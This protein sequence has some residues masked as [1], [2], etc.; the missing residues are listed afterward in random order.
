MCLNIYG[1]V[2]YRQW[3]WLAA[4][5]SYIGLDEFVVM[6]NHVHGIVI[7][8]DI[9]DVGTGRDLSLPNKIKSLS[10][11]IGAFKT[12]S[13]RLIHEHGLVDFAW[14]RSFYDHIIEDDDSLN[15]IR[16]YIR[17]NPKFWRRDRNYN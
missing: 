6:P 17:Y 16:T 5:Y 11:L 7:I 8:K 14:Q 10:E 3:S 9:Q 4:Q 13:S 12:T 2:L 1:A 15:E